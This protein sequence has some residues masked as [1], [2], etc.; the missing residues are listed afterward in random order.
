MTDSGEQSWRTWLNEVLARHEGPLLRYARRITG[1]AEQARD[2]VQ[3]SFV[4]LCRRRDRMSGN[5]TTQWLFKVCRSRAIDLRRKERRM[6]TLAATGLESRTSEGPTE[7]AETGETTG[8]MLALLDR[9]P[10]RQQKALVLKFQ[11][12]LS[13]REIA[14]VLDLSISHVGV[15]IRTGIKTLRERL[16]APSRSGPKGAES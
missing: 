10:D 13:Y 4:R 5:H 15:L 2:V 9:L 12:G 3:E 6:T 1:G 7:Q 11:A 8:R 16:A 14:D